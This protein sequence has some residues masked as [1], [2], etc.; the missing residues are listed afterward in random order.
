MNRAAYLTV[1]TL[2][3][4]CASGCAC[5]SLAVW[6]ASGF[7]GGDI[8]YTEAQREA[9]QGWAALVAISGFFGVLTSVSVMFLSGRI[10]RFILRLF[11]AG[12][13]A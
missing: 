5:V 7:I 4:L 3:C 11:G 2:I 1:V 10:A 9:A 13:A 6:A 12:G 8:D